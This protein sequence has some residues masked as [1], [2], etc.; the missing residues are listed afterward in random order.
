MKVRSAYRNASTSSVTNASR[1]GLKTL[2]AVRTVV[3]NCRLSYLLESPWRWSLYVHTARDW[4]GQVR[5]IESGMAFHRVIHLLRTLPV[6]GRAMMFSEYLF[7]ANLYPSNAHSLRSQ[8]EYQ[9]IMGR[10]PEHWGY[11]SANRSSPADSPE[12]R[13]RQ[14]RGRVGSNRAS[15]LL[16]RPT[17]LGSARFI[18]PPANPQ[19]VPQRGLTLG[20]SPPTSH[21]GGHPPRRSITPGLARQSSNSGHSSITPPRNRLSSSLSSSSEEAS[22]PVAVGSG[23]A[24]GGRPITPPATQQGHVS[25]MGHPINDSADPF[26]AFVQHGE[27]SYSPV[28]RPRTSRT[29]SNDV[30][31]SARPIETN[32]TVASSTHQYAFSEMGDDPRTTVRGLDVVVPV[33]PPRPINYSPSMSV[34]PWPRW[35]R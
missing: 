28:G 20:M 23:L 18:I 11:P 15:H 3:I 6:E 35:S 33:H 4:D 2:I 10:H 31:G 24:S 14:A 30:S 25:S 9:Y 21:H 13:R 17:S 1:N 7:M 29:Q 8:E 12:N 27:T 22:P 32:T 34:N 26:G 19:T 16:G 5:G